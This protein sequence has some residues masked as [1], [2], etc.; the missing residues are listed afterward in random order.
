MSTSSQNATIRRAARCSAPTACAKTTLDV[1]RAACARPRL[2]AISL[3]FVLYGI[4]R[5]RQLPELREGR[6]RALV[7]PGRGRLDHVVAELGQRIGG[8]AGNGDDDWIHR[9]RHR[10]L[11]RERDSQ[12]S[13]IRSDLVEKRPARRRRPVSIARL[14][15]GEHVEKRGGVAHRDRDR[16]ALGELERA[17]RER[18]GRDPTARRLDPEEAATRSRNADRPAAVRAVSEREHAGGDRRRRA[19]R[20]APGRARGIPR[21]PARAVQVGFRDGSDPELG[22]VALADH[23]E[24][25]FLHPPYDRRIVRRH[26]VRE[27][28][29][30]EGRAHTR[31]LGQILHEHRHA[32]ERP[33]C[34]CRRACLL[35]ALGDEEVQLRV[36]GLGAAD[37][38]VDELAGRNVAAAHLGGESEGIGHEPKVMRPCRSCRRSSP[39]RPSSRRAARPGLASRR[40]A[41]PR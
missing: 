41:S 25:G 35:E 20:R 7:D 37:R 30:R 17:A 13:W 40:G 2:I 14:V 27:R 9:M 28:S 1:S 19:A 38:V 23:D 32:A 22:R 39:I 15:A 8:S 31:R 36:R 6:E 26:V 29:R 12:P 10:G 5:R 24:A 18:C 34:G 4:K 21:V 33:V 3:R 16:A 11:G